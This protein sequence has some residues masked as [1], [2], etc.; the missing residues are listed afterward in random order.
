MKLEI[1]NAMSEQEIIEAL[2]TRKE[3]I[4]IARKLKELKLPHKKSEKYRYYDIESFLHKEI[5]LPKSGFEA[6]E[7]KNALII[8]N[9]KV[10]AIPKQEGVE[11]TFKEF[12]DVASNH[13]DSLYY[14]SHLLNQKAIVIRISKDSNFEIKHIVSSNEFLSYRIVLFVDSNVKAKVYESFEYCGDNLDRLLY[15]IDAIIARDASLDFIKNQT[16]N[17]SVEPI[18]TNYFKL[19]SNATC[20]FLT[21]DFTSKSGLNIFKAELKEHAHF[22]ATHLI[23]GTNSA[24]IGT[25]SEIEHTEKSAK[26]NQDARAILNEKARGIFDALIRVTKEGI[27]ASAHQNSK[28]ILLN[29]GAYMASKPQLEIYID[30]LEASHGSTTGQLDK[31]QLFYLRSRGINEVEARKMLILAFANSAIS[32]IEDETIFNRVQIDFEKAY[33]GDTKLDC[34][35]TCHE[36]E[37]NILKG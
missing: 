32:K 24:K 30:D 37:E 31:T 34:I 27:Y 13:F 22:D 28:A 20:N 10:I 35:K 18:A 5:T 2:G 19:D 26:S 11:V 23:Y 25:I 14:L 9:A 17:F 3:K 1:L 36:C 21:F 29:S 33:Y 8:E 4:E 16:L 15:G 7:H 12:S 6:K